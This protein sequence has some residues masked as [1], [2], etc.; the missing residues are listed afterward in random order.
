MRG[1]KAKP[2]SKSQIADMDDTQLVSNF[3][4][5]TLR[6]IESMVRVGLGPA[7]PPRR[8]DESVAQHR[9][10]TRDAKEVW[11]G[12][13]ARSLRQ[14]LEIHL[15]NSKPQKLAR[16]EYNLSLQTPEEAKESKERS[17]R[18]KEKDKQDHS[19]DPAAGERL[20][21]AQALDW[22]ESAKQGKRGE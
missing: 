8:S 10:R 19:Y 17:R 13:L 1:K 18:I 7:E 14:A 12:E 6:T 9:A 3:D 4:E 2:Y 5:K 22:N 21:N 20:G 15:F 16:V 11:E